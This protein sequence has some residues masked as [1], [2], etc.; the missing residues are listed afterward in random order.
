VHAVKYCPRGVAEGGNR[1]QQ[2]HHAGTGGQA[3]LYLDRD[4]NAARVLTARALYDLFPSWM[5]DSSQYTQLQRCIV[6]RQNI[7]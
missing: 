1:Q 4:R 2:Q 3:P 7:Q 5:H 6:R